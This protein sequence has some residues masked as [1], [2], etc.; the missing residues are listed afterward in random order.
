[1][2][3]A[4]VFMYAGHVLAVSPPSLWSRDCADGN[5]ICHT[6]SK[7]LSMDFREALTVPLATLAGRLFWYD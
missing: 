6:N 2:D 7:N 4:L 1:M 5:E 3:T